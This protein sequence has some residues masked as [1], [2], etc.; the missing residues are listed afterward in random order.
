MINLGSW[1]EMCF[2]IILQVMKCPYL[3]KRNKYIVKFIHAIIEKR[4]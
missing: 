2:N 3:R 4:Y 1:N